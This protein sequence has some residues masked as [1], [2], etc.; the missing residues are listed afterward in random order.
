MEELIQY[1]TNLLL[2][3]NN[4]FRRYLFDQ[5]PWESRFVVIKGLRGVGKTTMM[6]QYLKYELG[7]DRRYLYVTMDHPYFYENQLFDLV[8]HFYTSEGR[9]LFV[10]EIHKYKGWSQEIKLIYDSFPQ[11]QLIISASSALDLIK[12]EADLSRRVLIYELGGLS[13]REYLSFK[14]Q[15]RL[16]AF[17]LSEILVNH[18]SVASDIVEKI[19]PL[20]YFKSYLREGYFPFGVGEEQSLY[21]KRLN[22]VIELT[23]TQDLNYISGHSADMIYKMKKLLGVIAESSPFTI[24]VSNIAHK[25]NIGR[26]TVKSLI[27]ELQKAK[28]LNFLSRQGKGISTLQKPDKIYLENSN[29]SYALK[30]DINIGTLRETF[31]VNQLT[32]AG[33]SI[34]LPKKGDILVKNETV[35][36]I[37]GPSKLKK[38]IQDLP[39]S[40]VLKDEIEV[41]FNNVIPLWLLG[42][43]Y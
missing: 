10:D 8:H 37:G 39:N 14:H 12:G 18:N 40:Y 43:L 11:L 27:H 42:M 33:L 16:P 23:L 3:V 9:V 36:E 32:N 4:R 6:L 2:H 24:N 26:N 30:P 41:G 31:V 17:D 38:Q 22:Q 29:F 19:H 1:Q 28:I 5:V 25:L 20:P 35:F 34:H 13:F 21:Q 15:F 7:S